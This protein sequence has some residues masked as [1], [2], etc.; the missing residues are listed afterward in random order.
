MKLDRSEL[1]RFSVN[2]W[3]STEA[4]LAQCEQCIAHKPELPPCRDD[5]TNDIAPGTIPGWQLE[6]RDLK[7]LSR[8][9]EIWSEYVVRK[10][11]LDSGVP[12]ALVSRRYTQHPVEQEL[13]EKLRRTFEV[14]LSMG[15]VGAIKERTHA[16]VCMTRFL[17]RQKTRRPF[18]VMMLDIQFRNKL[19]EGYQESQLT[20]FLTYKWC[21]F[22]VFTGTSFTDWMHN[23]I[24]EMLQYRAMHRLAT[25]IVDES[26]ENIKSVRGLVEVVGCKV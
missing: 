1:D 19:R 24:R 6:N 7:A 13:L 14:G 21:L 23:D 22:V 10:T 17:A 5:S 11:M 2:W 9:C 26:S 18:H 4:R 25:V 12:E 3:R 15:V 8:P 20:Q 16:L